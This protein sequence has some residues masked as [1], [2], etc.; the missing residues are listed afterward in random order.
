MDMNQQLQQLRDDALT[1]LVLWAASKEYSPVSFAVGL[2]GEG[3]V[4]G[5]STQSAA[6]GRVSYFYHYNVLQALNIASRCLHRHG[7][8]CLA[9]GSCHAHVNNG[10]QCLGCDLHY[11][12]AASLASD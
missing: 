1:Y 8:T 5:L 2:V 7:C 11:V 10:R 4:I 12:A 6:V 3:W 9:L